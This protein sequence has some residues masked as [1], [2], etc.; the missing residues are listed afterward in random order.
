M[1]RRSLDRHGDQAYHDVMTKRHGSAEHAVG[2]VGEPVQVYLSGP[3]QARLER[4]AQQLAA[5]KSDVLRRG[6]EAL[7][8]STRRKHQKP[9]RV[10]PLP[11]YR[12]KGLQAGV[13]LDDT[14]SLVDL[15]EG[16]DAPP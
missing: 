14:A 5:S 15:M 8:A 13:D 12:G 6:L 4:L 1:A 9:R 2:R 7:E 3:D 10:A 11:T 16:A